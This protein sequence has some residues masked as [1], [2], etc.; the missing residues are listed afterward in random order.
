MTSSPVDLPIVDLAG[1]LDE[2]A[3]EV[4]RGCRSTGFFAIV[5]HGMEASLAT[6][7]D[8][9]RSFFDLPQDL[10]ERVPRVSSFGF[11]PHRHHALDPNRPTG[12]T[13]YLDLPIGADTD[14]VL[15]PLDDGVRAAVGQYQ[16]AVG[17]VADRV[18]TAIAVAL[19]VQPSFFADRMTAPPS[20]LRFLHY[21]PTPPSDN[22]TQ[23]IATDAHTD[24]GVV[25]LLAT[26]GVPGLELR[27]RGETWQPVTAPPEALIVNLGDLLAVW[28][29]LRYASTQHRVIS[30]PT[31]DR[32]SIPYFANVDD[33]TLV[34]VLPTCTGPTDPPRIE[35]VTAGD[36]LA[37]RIAKTISEPFIDEPGDPS[38]NLTAPTRSDQPPDLGA[39]SS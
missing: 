28:T 14:N 39:G 5:G 30:S 1:S 25:T 26:D 18:L 3:T 11:V 37:G 12:I 16:T 33:D 2:V 4:D 31:T 21:S 34:E 13:E 23:P 19:D 22:G 9:A 36:F 17:G 38:T 29:N 7:F 15:A 32:Y 27:P 6:V 10:K 20:K 8:A 24:Y 35:P